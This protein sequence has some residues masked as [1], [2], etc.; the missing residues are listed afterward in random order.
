[1]SADRF[2]RVDAI[3]DVALDLEPHAQTEF[4]TRECG[5]DVVLCNE[6]LR[7]LRALVFCGSFATGSSPRAA[8]W[9]L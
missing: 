2:A 6:V 1:M 4:V 7:L 8:R 3:F 5:D 9:T